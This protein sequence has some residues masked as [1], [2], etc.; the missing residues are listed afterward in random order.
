MLFGLACATS[1]GLTAAISF[2][3]LFGGRIIGLVAGVMLAVLAWVAGF[4]FSWLRRRGGADR[5]SHCIVDKL[6][7]M[8]AWPLPVTAPVD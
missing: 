1:L 2:T 5:R 8:G 3:R 4:V 6:N 7:G